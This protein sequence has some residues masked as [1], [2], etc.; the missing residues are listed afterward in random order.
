MKRSLAKELMDLPGNPPHVLE[1]D[2]RNLRT[3]NRY[4]G[5]YR[6]VLWGLERLLERKRSG[7]F[8]LLD[9]G[10]GGGD[11]PHA[12]VA[13]SRQRGLTVRVAAIEPNPLT[14]A[15]ARRQTLACPE[16]FVVRGDGFHPPFPP[17]S[18]DFVLTSQVLHHFA[19]EEIIELL[20]CWS[21][22]ARCALLVSD[23]IR[24]PLAYWGVFFLTR[25]FTHNPMTR[26]DAPLSVRRAFTMAEWRELFQR[27]GIGP[28]RLFPFFPFRF[29]AVFPREECSERARLKAAD[30][31]ACR[32]RQALP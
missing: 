16:I 26:T 31:G 9:A 19:E 5:G 23:L 30:A 14:V 8:S 28:F 32:F 22:L 4:L 2:L 6:T 1:E 12:I 7:N 27:A 29:L 21:G 11:L 15:L 13:W 24:H 20:R 3:L 17:S 25:L 18:F 10:T